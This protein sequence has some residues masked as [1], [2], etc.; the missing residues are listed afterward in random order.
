MQAHAPH[1]LSSFALA[2]GNQFD[3]DG[4]QTDGDHSPGLVAMNAVAAL[5][6]NLTIAWD[7]VDAL[8]NTSVP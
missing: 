6:S 2:D 1:P 7:F 4:T 3:L 8:W 5:G